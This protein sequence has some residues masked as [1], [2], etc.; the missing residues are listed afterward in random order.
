M[1][2]ILIDAITEGDQ[3]L[4][5]R[6]YKIKPKA[7]FEALAGKLEQILS[8]FQESNQGQIRAM[9]QIVSWMNLC[10]FQMSPELK[11]SNLSGSQMFLQGATLIG[12]SV[13][14]LS[15]MGTSIGHSLS[16]SMPE[17]VSMDPNVS[18]IIFNTARKLIHSSDE[19][20]RTLFYLSMSNP[21][22][23][24]D[25]IL[26]ISKEDSE[27][28]ILQYCAFQLDK[29]IVVIRHIFNAFPQ[30][31][32]PA[33]VNACVI[34]RKLIWNF[35]EWY[36]VDFVNLA[37][38]ARKLDDVIDLFFLTL[39]EEKK[40]FV[41]LQTMLMILNSQKLTASHYIQ[42][43]ELLRKHKK[44]FS[45]SLVDILK[46]A[47]FLK[48]RSELRSLAFD[49]ES[50]VREIVQLGLKAKDTDEG[51]LLDGLVGLYRISPP[52]TIKVF[53]S[54]FDNKRLLAKVFYAL[55]SSDHQ[56]WN[57]PIS[58][59]ASMC[60][61]VKTLLHESLLPEELEASKKLAMFD[62]KK[63]AEDPRK[64]VV[65]YVVKILEMEPKIAVVDDFDSVVRD[66]VS[67]LEEA[68]PQTRSV[69]LNVIQKTYQNGLINV[70]AK[71]SSLFVKAF[72]FILLS[73]S[74][75]IF[76]SKKEEIVLLLEFLQNFFDSVLTTMALDASIMLSPTDNRLKTAAI[77]S[78]ES[79][80]LYCLALT[81]IDLFC[82]VKNV[83]SIILVAFEKFDK[84]EFDLLNI[85]HIAIYKKL[86]EPISYQNMFKSLTVS[87]RKPSLSTIV[88][89]DQLYRRWKTLNMSRQ[90]ELM[91]SRLKRMST[92]Y[93][94][95]QS[96]KSDAEKET[97]SE[98]VSVTLSMCY[99]LPLCIPNES[100][101]KQI[102][103]A[104]TFLR[105]DTFFNTASERLSIH[106]LVDAFLSDLV[107]L[108]RSE[109][110]ILK[111]YLP[112]II[113]EELDY[114]FWSIIE[115]KLS[116]QL[117]AVSS[118]QKDSEY[119]CRIITIMHKAIS[120]NE[121]AAKTMTMSMDKML[122]FISLD[123]DGTKDAYTVEA[124]LAFCRL[125]YTLFE[126]KAD[127]F[128]DLAIKNFLA[129]IISSWISD[130]EYSTDQ[131]LIFKELD[132]T[133]IKCL[134]F[135][136]EGLSL[137]PQN[138]DNLSKTDLKEMKERTFNNYVNV[139]Q[140]VLYK[141][142]VIQSG[143]TSTSIYSGKE[144]HY[145]TDDLIQ[146]FASLVA[147][148]QDIGLKFIIT[149]AQNSSTKLRPFV[150][151]ILSKSLVKSQQSDKVETVEPTISFA[152]LK[153]F[154]IEYDP[155]ICVILYENID[156]SIRE[157]ILEKV[158]LVFDEFKDP[159]KLLRTSIDRDIGKTD[160]ANVIFRRNSMSTKLLTLVNQK[161]GIAYLKTVVQPIVNKISEDLKNNIQFEIDP[162]KLSNPQELARNTQNLKD[163]C[164]FI[165]N[166]IYGNKS[167]IPIVI[168][169][170][171]NIISNIVGQKFPDAKNNAVSGY[172]FLRFVCPAIVSPEGSGLTLS[173]R[174]PELSRSL[175]LIAK[176][177]QNLANFVFFG[178]KEEFMTTLNVF[179]E[180]HIPK[181]SDFL[182]EISVQP[183]KD[184]LNQFHLDSIPDITSDLDMHDIY[185]H[186]YQ[187]KDKIYN[188]LT[189][190]SR[191][192]TKS[193]DEE[194][195]SGSTALK[196]IKEQFDQ[197]IVDLGAPVPTKVS[198]TSTG[199]QSIADD[200]NLSKV[201]NDLR[202]KYESVDGS[203]IK[204][205]GF[206]TEGSRTKERTPGIVFIARR[207]DVSQIDLEHAIY[208][209]YS[210]LNSIAH[211]KYYILIDLTGFAV[212]NAISEIVIEKISAIVTN[213]MIN[214]VK[215]IF[216]LNPNNTLRGLVKN[217]PK[218]TIEMFKKATFFSTVQQ[219]KELFPT[220]SLT[221]PSLTLSL[222]E[223]TVL[224]SNTIRNLQGNAYPV[225]LLLGKNCI[226]IIS[227][228]KIEITAGIQAVLNDVI[229]VAAVDEVIKKKET[230][231]EVRFIIKT[232]SEEYDFSSPNFNQ[233]Y[234]IITQSKK[235]L[236][237][238][239][240]EPIEKEFGLDSVQGSLLV[241]IFS[242]LLESNTSLQNSAYQLYHAL[243]E[244]L[245]ITIDEKK[246]SFICSNSNILSE[247]LV[248]DLIRDSSNVAV[249]FILEACQY[250][251]N[252]EF[253]SNLDFLSLLEPCIDQICKKI[254]S[255]SDDT[256]TENM[257]KVLKCLLDLTSNHFEF[258]GILTEKIWA[259]MS[260]NPAAANLV[261]DIILAMNMNDVQSEVFLEILCAVGMNINVVVGKILSCIRKTL[262]INSD[263]P[264]N[265]I[266]IHLQILANYAF[267]GSLSVDYYLADV[268]Y[269]II[270]LA[271][272]GNAQ[273]RI[274]VYRL[275]CNLVYSIN[276]SLDENLL[277]Y[278][279]DQAEN[280]SVLNLFGLAY[281]PKQNLIG[282]DVLNKEPTLGDVGHLVHLIADIL[283]CA[284]KS[285]DDLHAHRA[286][287][288]GLVSSSAFQY[289][290]I[291]QPRAFVALGALSSDD[292]DDDLI[293]QILMVPFINLG[294]EI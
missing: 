270:S 119:L 97:K 219:L 55:A 32:K 257:N 211:D 121:T 29:L 260:K 63:K 185:L 277:Q 209:T 197:I 230:S 200:K 88:C 44:E 36:P 248:G 133:S 155:I 111:E 272:Q 188:Q 83:W 71:N 12:G 158:F 162:L 252:Q 56:P 49:F 126:K 17:I 250:L 99:L 8:V 232:N 70:W 87:L 135:L 132:T 94:Y 186:L 50:D 157:Q 283:I 107:N 181:T 205:L 266:D 227:T 79:A 281:L 4:I 184:N 156:V 187:Q 161:Y 19:V 204:N 3:D 235:N 48:D 268:M 77:H 116:S 42:F 196:K 175:V 236:T 1:E 174:N 30:L 245:E 276:D 222:D 92:K 149:M 68:P 153:S 131:C 244:K 52:S 180:K 89:F 43:I 9:T 251:S 199:E 249:P 288:M 81:D 190:K 82:G 38:G 271:G 58:N 265:S 166:K 247:H 214:N 275:L 20:I 142:H 80:L 169:N 146:S 177:I 140:K 289:N 287:L 75:L 224:F 240:A 220:N 216:V 117:N 100:L 189:L 106:L 130:M 129:Q 290:K 66:I 128:K 267:N 105:F 28:N 282:S 115:K 231:S 213:N 225:H 110:P 255:G 194:H 90:Q 203:K 98:W 103:E 14:S 263:N 183:N 138:N 269:L 137:K 10:L 172:F 195:E 293:Y 11:Q 191:S 46:A 254:D 125:V 64:D 13:A 237:I 173:N 151:N 104:S 206:I 150:L 53:S 54:M 109:N 229:D 25:H 258:I 108:L 274:N 18:L 102:Y 221:L 24:I 31:K 284:S 139:L 60:T 182:N 65:Y 261:T 114:S 198:I 280:E 292:A 179:V 218:A 215:N 278:I 279:T 57:S 23:I 21:Q 59:N 228:K 159:Y 241:L 233:I 171:C 273:Q 143:A 41:Q 294:V 164:E 141:T 85:P 134:K 86:L 165:M 178:N 67:V 192:L 226:Q 96:H 239:K 167:E 212:E 15:S 76:E 223:P 246:N 122:S 154:L 39:N 47:V 84:D 91:D 34:C 5:T 202:K 264:L 27:M 207:Y 168:R 208:Y 124:K 22:I 256:S 2:S 123:I 160:A 234:Q 217:F 16:V 144:I 253:Y 61:F 243:V 242:N 136:F 127:V 51:L 93:S 210:L 40:K 113:G 118:T 148:N 69:A 7:V 262:I 6:L 33:Q 62:K 26:R 176:C 152:S 147:A 45:S 72:S 73:I 145:L 201:V 170:V 163:M 120:K 193:K 78:V 35:I 101:E 238:V 259:P 95:T 74:K 37:S 286:R 112:H 291:L 285:L